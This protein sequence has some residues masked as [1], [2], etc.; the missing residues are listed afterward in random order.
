M[1]AREVAFY[2]QARSDWSVFRHLHPRGYR[3]WTTLRQAWC[4]VA[5]VRPFAFPPCHELHYLQMRTEKLAKAYSR[6]QYHAAATRRSA[7]S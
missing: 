4:G 3:W 6:A 5:G 2:R 1:N 7:D